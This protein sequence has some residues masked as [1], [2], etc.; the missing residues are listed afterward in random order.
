MSTLLIEVSKVD[1][2]T[3]HP[4]ADRLE[5]ATVKGWNTCVRKGEFKAGDLCIFFPPDSVLPAELANGPDDPIPGRLNVA[6][7][8]TPLPK[9]EN[10]NRPNGGRLKATRLRG[11]QSY[12]LTMKIDPSKG[13]DPN[14][15]VGDN[16]QEHFGITK[17]EPPVESN[18]GDAEV[19]HSFFYKYT[20]IEHF[21]N[22]PDI[23][24]DGEEV[25]FIEKIHGK[26]TRLG[27]VLNQDATGNA[28]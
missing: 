21:G 11:Q 23:I 13:D 4:M 2:I 15:K 10:G 28:L 1:T 9:D 18:E 14:W 6:K 26:N 25:V 17:W 19:P 7:Y 3:Q 8:L 22:Y 27:L 12:G 16:V 5:I 20:D 24:P